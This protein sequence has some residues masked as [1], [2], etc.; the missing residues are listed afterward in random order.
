[1][2]PGATSG[3]LK[4][5]IFKSELDDS[6]I[7]RRSDPAKLGRRRVGVG[8][9]EVNVVEHVEEFGAEHGGRRF[10]LLTLVLALLPE[11]W[12]DRHSHPARARLTQPDGACTEPVRRLTALAY[13]LCFF[14]NWGVQ[15]SHQPPSSPGGD[16]RRAQARY[17]LP[18]GGEAQA[19][20][21]Y[22]A[23]GT[24]TGS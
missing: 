15:R 6:G 16:D 4:K 8:R 5:I 21:T 10:D 13:R 2:P 18:V 14:R 17:P 12:R 24:G 22:V 20:T 3:A 9:P 23:S 11:R 1:M 7:R 19:R